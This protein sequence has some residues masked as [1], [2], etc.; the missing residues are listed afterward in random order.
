MKKKIK[1]KEKIRYKAGDSVVF[2]QGKDRESHK[3]LAVKVGAFG[4]IML[5]L[6]YCPGGGFNQ[7]LFI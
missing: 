4:D 7:N 5:E 6:D 2:K 3:V 1:A